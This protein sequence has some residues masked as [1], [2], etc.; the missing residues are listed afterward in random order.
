[1]LN[2]F[3]AKQFVDNLEQFSNYQISI[4]DNT[5]LVIYSTT[6]NSNN[7]FNRKDYLLVSDKKEALDKNSLNKKGVLVPIVLDSDILGS[8]S[9]LGAINEVKPIALVLKMAMEI[10][11]KYDVSE[12]K[13]RE[14]LSTN[15]QLIDKLIQYNSSLDKDIIN[16]F[17]AGNYK[18]NIVR[19][20]IILQ[21]KSNLFVES[22][23]NTNMYYDSL[24]DIVASHNNEVIVL[25][26]CSSLI[27]K[28]AN[29]FYHYITN[30]CNHIY[31]NTTFSG[32]IFICHLQYDYKNFQI[33]Y[34]QTKWLENYFLL[35]HP[36]SSKDLIFFR[37][38]IDYYF[39]SNTTGDIHKE[40]FQP[41][42]D[43][44][45]QFSADEFISLAKVLIKNNYNLTQS[46]KDLFMHKN[47]LI[48]KLEKLKQT[49]E[50]DP[51]NSEA[52]RG[53]I[54]NLYYYIIYTKAK[55]DKGEE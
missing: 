12:T 6:K 52:D 20:L 1:M 50:I 51:I 11:L 30:Y 8:I 42:L 53:F 13:D 35:F 48:Y 26:D 15:E 7:F 32:K 40:I 44:T 3:I 27:K 5:D 22:L 39:I 33:N 4:L 46:S 43:K 21:P 25:K 29:S 24:Q 37:D 16:L 19:T 34:V 18:A 31:E 54:K 17:K 28:N 10:R 36:K 14:A 38:Y 55:D 9:I 2:K 45:K 41:I 23:V 49:F 47:T